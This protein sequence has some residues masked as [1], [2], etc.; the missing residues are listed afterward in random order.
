MILREVATHRFSV[1]A[2]CGFPGEEDCEVELFLL[3]NAHAY[4]RA[5][6]DLSSALRHWTPQNGPPFEVEERAKRL[7]EGICEFRAREKRKSKLP[8][9]L[10]FE[11]GMVVI[12]TN[13]FLKTGST[14][15]GEIDRAIE[16]RKAYFRHKRQGHLRI[17]KGWAP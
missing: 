5:M 2:V 16:I 10:F 13:A 3:N 14:P 11:D 8:R 12:C 7:R 6:R 4:P 9:I 17:L 1:Y 15:D